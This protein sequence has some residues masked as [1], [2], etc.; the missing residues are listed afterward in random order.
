MERGKR[1]YVANH[2]QPNV[3]PAACPKLRRAYSNENLARILKDLGQRA[4]QKERSEIK[5]KKK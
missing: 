4:K 3:G 5:I 1:D 2:R